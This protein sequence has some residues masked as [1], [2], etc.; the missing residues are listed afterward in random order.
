MLLYMVGQV[1]GERRRKKKV[2]LTYLNPTKKSKWKLVGHKTYDYALWQA[3]VGGL[4]L[5]AD[6]AHNMG[7]GLIG[8]KM[9]NE[10]DSIRKG[11]I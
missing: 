10:R 9:L 7:G 3:S 1:T 4:V 5:L 2:G 8:K 11:R 6:E